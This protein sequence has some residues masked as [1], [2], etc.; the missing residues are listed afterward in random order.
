MLLVTAGGNDRS[1]MQ[2]RVTKLTPPTID[3]PE[4]LGNEGQLMEAKKAG[5]PFSILQLPPET[6]LDFKTLL[7]DACATPCQDRPP[8][9]GT[10]CAGRGDALGA[11]VC[12]IGARAG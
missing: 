5:Q 7:A 4:L 11:A 10:P 6:P 3:D 12:E 9:C 2:W 8:S 1:L